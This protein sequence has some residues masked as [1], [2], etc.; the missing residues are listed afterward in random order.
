MIFYL[1]HKKHAYTMGCYLETFAPDLADRIRPVSYQEI[2]QTPPGTYIFADVERLKVKEALRASRLWHSLE[3]A[4]YRLLN[5][6]R[7]SMRRYRL[8][9]SLHRQGSNTFNVF[10]PWERLW[11]RLHYPVFLRGENDH[12]GTMS[13]LISTPRELFRAQCRHRKALITEFCDTRGEDGLYRKYSAMR[14]GERILPRHIFFSKHWMIKN[15]DA[16]DDRLLAEEL[17]YLHSNPHEKELRAIFDLARIE[18]GRID[19]GLCNGRIQV[20]EINTNPSVLTGDSL[21]IDLRRVVAETFAGPFR[22]ALLALDE[23]PDVVAERSP[24]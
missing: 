23:A 14:I 7:R 9:K 22:A 10:R 4:G 16:C 24:V 18:Y 11:N 13:D 17:D 21:Q 20:W 1:T 12:R 19:Y 15:A 5:H 8:L 2:C 6:P 3:R